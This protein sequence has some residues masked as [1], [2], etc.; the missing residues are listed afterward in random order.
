MIPDNRFLRQPKRFWANVRLLSEHI[1][2][3]QRSREGKGKIKIPTLVEVVDALTELG[4][5]ADHLFTSEAKPTPT[6]ETLLAYFG[7]RANML[8]REASKNL[9]NAVEAKTEFERLRKRLQPRC[10]IPMNKQKGDK[11]A[12]AFL[13]GI[14]NMIVEANAAGLPCNYNPLELTTFTKDKSPVRTLA[15]R[16]DGAFPSTVNPVALWEIKEYYYTTTFGSRVADGVYESLLDG[17]ELE[18]LLEEEGIET[19]HYLIVDA[20]DTWWND[21]KSYLCR[22]VDMLHMGYVDE[23]LFG[24]EVIKNLPTIVR[25]WVK[26]ARNRMKAADPPVITPTTTNR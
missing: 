18:N 13:T 19:K 21:G 1:G 14:V 26:I 3:T 9:M 25:E 16:V 8:N 23:V 2:Y 20:H 15:R 7:H 4:L 12:P 10:P 11:K 6:G 5:S 22:I 17:L 24:R